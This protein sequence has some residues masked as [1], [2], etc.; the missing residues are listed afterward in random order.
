MPQKT[1]KTAINTLRE[2]APLEHEFGLHDKTLIEFNCKHCGRMC[3]ISDAY[4][5]SG[6]QDVPEADLTIDDVRPYHRACWNQL[7]KINKDKKK[8]V[9]AEEVPSNIPA[10]WDDNAN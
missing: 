9:G 2:R 3:A 1:A 4:V 10:L 8:G 6:R 5:K 7:Q